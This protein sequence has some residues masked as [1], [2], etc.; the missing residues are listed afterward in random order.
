MHARLTPALLVAVLIAVPAFG[1]EVVEG[2]PLFR[3][4]VVLLQDSLGLRIDSGAMLAMYAGARNSESGLE[5]E[6]GNYRNVVIMIEEPGAVLEAIG[7]TKERI[8]TRV[9]LRLRSLNLTRVISESG[10]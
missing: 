6:P 10:V 7:L 2:N 3:G 5:V 8:K 9:E 1:Q 4:E